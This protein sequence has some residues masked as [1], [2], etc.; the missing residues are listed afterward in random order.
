MSG[1]SHRCLDAPTPGEP[2]GPLDPPG[3]F[4]PGIRRAGAGWFG[5]VPG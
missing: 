2:L 1:A 5:R 4:V 3:R